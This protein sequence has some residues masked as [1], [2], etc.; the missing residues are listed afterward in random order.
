M[1]FTRQAAVA[2]QN[3]R[4]FDEIRHRAAQQEA[5]NAIIAAAVTAPDL[6]NLLKVVLK[7]T[8]KALVLKKGAIWVPGQSVYS[9]SQANLIGTGSV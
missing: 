4:L 5:I 3:A 1:A 7:L 6:P 2:L 8:L 9:V